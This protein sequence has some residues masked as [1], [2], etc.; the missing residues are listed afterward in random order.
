MR[1]PSEE[2][3]SYDVALATAAFRVGLHKPRKLESRKLLAQQVFV[4]P[5]QA[6]H[7]LRECMT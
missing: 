5:H 3:N 4:V 2:L 1:K 7:H 6:L